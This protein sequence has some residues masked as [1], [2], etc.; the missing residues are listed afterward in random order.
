MDNAILNRVKHQ[1]RNINVWTE[2][3]QVQM[4]L[5]K[6]EARDLLEK[7]RKALSRYFQSQKKE[8]DKLSSTSAECRK[9]FLTTVE[10]LESSLFNET[11]TNTTDYDK[12][13][14][15]ILSYIYALEEQIKYNYPN[16]GLE[17][18]NRLESFKSKM[19]AFRVNLALHD[20]DNPEQ[21]DQLRLDF[22][23]KLSDIR[24]LLKNQEV[25]QT[26][27]NNFKEDISESYNY[28]KRAITDL[29][30]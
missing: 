9:E 20:K 2:E 24:Q 7:E 23:Q 28:L 19:D 26:K 15:S 11:P 8:I 27:L 3:L 29:A 14:G 5:G 1:I 18:Q 12:Y 16:Y 6:A 21:V 30:N 22:T 10:N 25:A 13:K 17:L 4:V